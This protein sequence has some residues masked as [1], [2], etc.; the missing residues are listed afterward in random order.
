MSIKESPIYQMWW[1]TFFASRRW[2]AK[3][4]AALVCGDTAKALRVISK[5]KRRAL[6]AQSHYAQIASGPVNEG[7]YLI[8][9]HHSRPLF[10][11]RKSDV[12][13]AI[14]EECDVIYDSFDLWSSATLSASLSASLS[15]TLSATSAE[16]HPNA[17][18]GKATEWV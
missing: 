8:G 7:G 16:W 18:R 4:N 5:A 10:E 15:A 6:R 14:A 17:Q 1:K 2:S 11:M 13:G 9:K 12:W 3:I